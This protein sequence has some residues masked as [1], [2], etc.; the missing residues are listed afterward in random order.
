MAALRF[1]LDENVPV[2]LGAALV[3][4][5]HTVELVPANLRSADDADILDLAVRKR[6]VLITL[7]TDFGT[8]VFVRRLAPPPAVVLIRL[9]SQQLA[10]SLPSVAAAI[11]ETA[12]VTGSFIVIGAEGVRVRPLPGDRL[13]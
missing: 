5:G 2:S 3:A 4:R 13:H 11:E 6:C 10:E 12:A 7:D 9:R 1:L 8:L